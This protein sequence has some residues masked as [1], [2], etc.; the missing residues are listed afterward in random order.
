GGGQWRVL[1]EKD[2]R[3]RREVLGSRARGLRVRSRERLLHSSL[4]GLV[5]LAG[6]LYPIPSRTPPLNSP[7]PRVLSLKTWKSRSLPGLP[8]TNILIA[9]IDFKKPPL[10]NQRRFFHSRF[11]FLLRLPRAP[12]RRDAAAERFRHFGEQAP[13]RPRRRLQMRGAPRLDPGREPRAPRRQR[14]MRGSEAGKHRQV[15]AGAEP[16]AQA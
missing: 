15:L 16:G 13:G 12:Q 9:M 3:L 2:L 7:A 6:G 1:K 8:R 5:V 4:A 11:L 10:G 14:L